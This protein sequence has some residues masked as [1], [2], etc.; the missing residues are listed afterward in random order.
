MDDGIRTRDIQIHNLD[1]DSR[2]TNPENDLRDHVAGLAHCLPTDIRQTHPDLAA[3]VDAWP[4]LS[5]ATRAAMSKLAKASA[6]K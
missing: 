3:I 4:N 1:A 5:P 2:K 6:K